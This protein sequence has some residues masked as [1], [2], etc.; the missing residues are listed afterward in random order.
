MDYNNLSDRLRDQLIESVNWQ[1]SGIPLTEGNTNGQDEEEVIE[2]EEEGHTCPLCASH[3][4]EEIDE[5]SLV[6]HLSIVM[7]ILERLETINEDTDE[8]GDLVDEVLND[9]LEE[10]EQDEDEDDE[11]EDED[12]DSDEDEYE[13]EEE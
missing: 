13:E 8:D 12:E 10:D 9:I 3:L 6:E 2:E 11:D 7:G 5:D 1:D 4:E